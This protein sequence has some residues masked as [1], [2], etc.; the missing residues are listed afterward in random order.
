MQFLENEI[1]KYLEFVWSSLDLQVE[2]DAG[3]FE[4]GAENLV[5][6]SI[7]ISGAWTGVIALVMENALANQIAEKM[8][9][10]EKGDAGEQEIE[11]A[12]SEMTNMIGG[13]LKALLPQP[14]HLSL[15]M[16]D[17]KGNI[18]NFPFTEL[19]SKAYFKT[20]GHKLRVAI[21]QAVE[22]KQPSLT[23]K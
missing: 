9:F 16:V 6:G 11:D 3:K 15:P 13:N 17:L 2:P 12:V 1:R 5:A 19:K 21:H 7:Q 10:L 18:F 22:K 14:S 20:N 23:G 8:F 4:E